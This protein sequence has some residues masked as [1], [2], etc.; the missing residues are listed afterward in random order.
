MLESLFIVLLI[1]T[2]LV[3][4][5]GF[6]TKRKAI[7]VIAFGSALALFGLLA[8]FS[9]DIEQTTCASVVTGESSITLYCDCAGGNQEVTTTYTSEWQCNTTRNHDDNMM[10]VCICASLLSLIF[11][12]ASIFA[13]VKPDTG[14]II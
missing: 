7:R 4:V 1:L 10:W 2:A 8:M 3:F 12:F 5:L 14:E 13:E 9:L 11:F 6:S